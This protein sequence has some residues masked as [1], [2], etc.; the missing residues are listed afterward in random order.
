MPNLY[1]AE[2]STNGGGSTGTL[3]GLP[4]VAGSSFT[5]GANPTFRNLQVMQT[6]QGLLPFE[7]RYDTDTI[8]IACDAGS[9]CTLQGSVKTGLIPVTS[10][11]QTIT[12]PASWRA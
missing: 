2:F 10:T 6:A 9:V 7:L 4:W 1:I 11:P 3:P 12:T 8:A 5:P